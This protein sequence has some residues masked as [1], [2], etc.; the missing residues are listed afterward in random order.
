MLRSKLTISQNRNLTSI[1]YEI[2]VTEANEQ[3]VV[4][5]EPDLIAPQP[6]PLQPRAIA[7]TAAILLVAAAAFGVFLFSAETDGNS[8]NATVDK[9]VIVADQIRGA[10]GPLPQS[11]NATTHVMTALALPER[12]KERVR[13]MLKDGSLRMGT[14][15]LW[16]TIDEDADTVS[17]SSA[18]FIQEHVIKHAP[19]TFFVPYLPGSSVRITALHDGGGGVTLGVK[20]AFGDV[21]LPRLHVGQT[22]EIPI[23]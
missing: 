6:L 5:P 16:D 2:G 17:I 14:I 13:E 1:H 9:P 21:P 22:I 11:L 8:G 20:T 7:A 18:G 15:T 23:L 3:P 10:V 4:A 12:E 19:R